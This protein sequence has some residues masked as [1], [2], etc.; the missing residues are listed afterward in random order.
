MHVCIYVCIYI[1]LVKKEQTIAPKCYVERVYVCVFVISSVF[2]I[3]CCSVGWL[4]GFVGFLEQKKI[5]RFSFEQPGNIIVGSMNG[6]MD[7]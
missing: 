4:V 7:S 1:F 2:I 5:S 3:C 6:W